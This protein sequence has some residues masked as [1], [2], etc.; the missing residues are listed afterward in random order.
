MKRF[1]LAALATVLTTVLAIAA[2]DLT[3]STGTKFLAGPRLIDGNDLNIML[4]AVNKAADQL[5]G[6][7]AITPSCVVTGSASAA[8]CNG[9]KGVVTTA[10]LTTAALTSAAYTITNS[11]VTAASQVSCQLQG[12]SGVLFTAGEPAIMT[13]VPGAGS[14]VANIGNLHASV[15]L[16]GTLTIG[17]RVTN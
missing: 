1:L 17:F 8:T 7:A 13:C 5:D 12:Y 15:A 14:I 10:S 4:G 3:L 6:T 9:V 16:G 11:S 2:N